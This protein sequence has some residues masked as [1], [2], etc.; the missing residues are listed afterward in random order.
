MAKF[1]IEQYE[2]HVQSYEVEADSLSEAIDKFQENSAG[3]DV[4]LI[5]GSFE[6]CD[7]PE[8]GFRCGIRKIEMPDGKELQWDIL[9]I[10][11]R[12][13]RL[14]GTGQTEEGPDEDKE[15]E[16]AEKHQG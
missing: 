1:I 10:M 14:D 3:E 4:E 5:E 6:F 12:E 9:K 2:R 11:E 7:I 13:D 15:E 16:Q 8:D